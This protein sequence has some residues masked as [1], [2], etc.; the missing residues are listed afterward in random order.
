MKSIFWPVFWASIGGIFVLFG[1]LLETL[2]D[3]R[4]FKDIRSFRCWGSAKSW[5]EWMV[6]V[7]VFGEVIVGGVTAVNEWRNDPMKKPIAFA[8]ARVQL[9]VKT[10]SN[11]V[12]LFIN[13]DQVR[14]CVN[15]GLSVCKNSVSNNLLNLES[16]DITSWRMGTTNQQDCHIRF[17][18][19]GTL[20]DLFDDKFIKRS[21]T[22]VRQ[23]EGAD[24]VCLR[25]PDM[26][27]N[28]EVLSGVV[29]LNVNDFTWRFEIPSQKPKW[30][31]TTTQKTKNGSFQIFQVSMLFQQADGTVLTNLYDGK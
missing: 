13:P 3:K 20:S 9:V 5:G 2:S 6:I 26:E 1:V 24:I 22:T 30:G 28:A 10:R 4:S 11:T 27:T 31:M 19:G 23:I 17:S 18:E 16:H 25:L 8:S 12:P 21:A 29:V 7:G 15:M 14:D